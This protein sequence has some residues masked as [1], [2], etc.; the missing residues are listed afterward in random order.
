M[1]KCLVLISSED[2]AFKL[3]GTIR[4]FF[5]NCADPDQCEI[6]ILY[7]AS[8]ENNKKQYK[9]LAEENAVLGNV[10]FIESRDFKK[11]LLWIV[12][13]Y[14][15]CLFLTDDM[16]FVRGFSILDIISNLDLNSDMLAF[17]LGLG[18]NTIFNSQTKDKQPLPEFKK[19]NNNIYKFNWTSSQNDFSLPL[20][21]QGFFYRTDD[22]FPVMA[23]ENFTDVKTFASSLSAHAR[24]FAGQKPL[25]F[26]YEFSAAYRNLTEY[27]TNEDNLSKI[28][29]IN[30]AGY[31][32]Y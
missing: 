6:K 20:Q 2:D 27:K 11:D 1:K 18:K 21:V 17:S 7:K 23:N 22:I 12:A 13:P 4:S 31:Q 29:R 32:G 5:F 24:E 19:I 25:L 16:I 8:A 15:Y 9:H 14:E 28:T 26:N 10:L 30:V 3:D